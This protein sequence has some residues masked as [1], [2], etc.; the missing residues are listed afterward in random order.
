MSG[1]VKQVSVIGFGRFGQ[2]L[3][4]IFKDDFDVLVVDNGE[5][6]EA[7]A[8]VEQKAAAIG[9][10]VVDAA[11]AMQADAVFYCVPISLLESTL[12]AHLPL[13]SEHKP[14][15]VADV[16]SVKVH[17]KTIFEKLLPAGRQA[18]LTHPMFGYPTALPLRAWPARRWLSTNTAARTMYIS[19]GADILQAKN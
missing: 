16:L 12:A 11:R 18:L 10:T 3:A 8:A 6:P 17:A 15:L 2:L 13:F 14:A 9:V 7:I 1:Q 5:S 4:G 19:F